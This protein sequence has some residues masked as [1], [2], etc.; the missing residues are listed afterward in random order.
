[1][2]IFVPIVDYPTTVSLTAERR[3]KHFAG[4][5]VTIMKMIMTMIFSLK[6]AAMHLWP[7]RMQNGM[8][9]YLESFGLIFLSFK[10]DLMVAQKFNFKQNTDADRRFNTRTNAIEL[11]KVKFI[12]YSKKYLILSK[13]AF[14]T[15]VKNFKDAIRFKK[16]QAV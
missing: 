15:N 11:L 5:L 4:L 12:D 9:I 10:Q 7:A 1:V 6:A 2:F 16:K 8:V 13:D 3:L 14:Y